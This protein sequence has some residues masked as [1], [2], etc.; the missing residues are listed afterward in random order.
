MRRRD[1]VSWQTFSRQL[2]AA[3]GFTST[4]VSYNTGI[5][6]IEGDPDTRVQRNQCRWTGCGEACG[7]GYY[8]VFRTDTDRHSDTEYMMDETNCKDGSYYTLCCP[9]YG[10]YVECGWYGFWNGGCTGVCPS[11]FAQ[12]GSSI[13]ACYSGHPQAACCT[14]RNVDQGSDLGEITAAALYANCYWEG[15]DHLYYCGHSEGDKCASGDAYLVA[16]RFGSGGDWCRADLRVLYCCGE[17]TDV[18]EWANCYW[19]KKSPDSSGYCY[20]TCPYGEVRVAMESVPPGCPSGGWAYCC[21]P[22]Y[23]TEAVSDE[24]EANLLTEALSVYMEDPVCRDTSSS[25]SAARDVSS[26]V[27]SGSALAVRQPGQVMAHRDAQLIVRNN[28]VR[29]VQGTVGPFCWR[30]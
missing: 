25:T 5:G 10:P 2:Q 17:Q 24:D 23:K 6:Q 26:A 13:A 20:P 12:V 27:G 18:K 30:S 16:S 1:D 8:P 4:G 21:T 7:S 3:T 28:V 14:T 15:N 19:Q 11:G 29:I 22:V 9:A